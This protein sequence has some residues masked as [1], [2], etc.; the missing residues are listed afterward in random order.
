MSDVEQEAV[1]AALME[2]AH[3]EPDHAMEE[4]ME[5]AGPLAI[6]RG[7]FRDVD[8]VHR[9]SG[10]ATLYDT[11]GGGRLLRFEDFRVTNGPA[12]V[13]VLAEA[14]DPTTAA[15]VLAGYVELGALKGNVGSQN[16]PVPPDLDVSRYHSAV[17]W[18][19]L[20][21]VLFSPATLDPV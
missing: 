11:P 3:A 12:L 5:V 20:F 13:V 18:C 2:Q 10:T 8:S 7:S 9:G 17:I 1:R 16:Y 14:K 15:D 6:A 19:E 21:D 4:P